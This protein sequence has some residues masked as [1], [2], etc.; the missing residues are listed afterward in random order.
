MP[1]PCFKTKGS[2]PPICGLHSVVLEEKQFPDDKTG[3]RGF[4][5]LAC[6]VSGTVLDAEAAHK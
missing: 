4:A 6:P 3:N 2:N 5:Y 1:E